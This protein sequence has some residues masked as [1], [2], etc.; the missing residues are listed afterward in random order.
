MGWMIRESGGD[1]PTY[2]TSLQEMLHV[3]YQPSLFTQLQDP[4]MGVSFG[5]VS[6]IRTR[7]SAIVFDAF[8]R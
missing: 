7:A 2:G 8:I 5:E 3:A 1:P 6:N 4:T